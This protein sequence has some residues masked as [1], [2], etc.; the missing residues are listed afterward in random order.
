MLKNASSLCL[1]LALACSVSCASTKPVAT[2]V[3]PQPAAPVAVEPPPHAE[4]P[5]PPTVVGP[6]AAVA[7]DT[8]SATFPS[9]WQDPKFEDMWLGQ[10]V[11]NVPHQDW[12]GPVFRLSDRFPQTPQDDSGAQAWRSSKYDRMFAPGTPQTERSTL[13]NDYIWALMRYIQEGNIDSGDVA[14]D[15]S[16]CNNK[17]R[18]WYHIPFQTYDVRSGREFVHGL[19]REASVPFSL[20]AAEGAKSDVLPS[21][22]WA[23]AFYNPTAAYTLGTV[24][25]PDGTAQPPANDLAFEQGAVIGK[26]LF[27]TLAPEQM[28][29]LQNVPA[30]KANISKQDCKC[31]SKPCANLAEWSKACPRSLKGTHDSMVR[32]MQFDVAV[33]DARAAGTGWVFGTFVADGERRAAE[34]NPWNRIA[35][36]GLM[37]GNDGP[38][39]GELAA[40]TPHDPRTNG[41]TSEVIFWDTV[42]M[43]NAAGGATVAMRPGHLGCNSR[44]NGPADNASSSCMSCHMTA[45]VP[46]D[47]GMTPP[48]MAQFGG[49]TFECVTPDASDP[50]KGTDA[51]GGAAKVIH[52]VGFAQMDALFFANVPC[53]TPVSM[54]A[55]TAAGPVNVLGDG[56]PTYAAGHQGWIS[57]DYS[58]QL[59]IS[60]VQWGQWQQV[61]SASKQ[62]K[63]RSAIEPLL[64][65]R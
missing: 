52:D 58:L 3:E 30:W 24:W 48:I 15:W 29:F 49:I 62:A 39:V 1:L 35:P 42:D 59:S 46:D 57:L 34:P 47:K 53:G 36:L 7:S 41:F 31:S 18:N 20:K 17:V 61:A 12:S 19:T 38:K 55:Q 65:G 14:S 5:A 23:V 13:A 27:S 10:Q 28:P 45:S 37:W 56:V 64:P 44:L 33:K 11:T 26:L 4:P 63:R 6:K 60:L 51:G 8:C 54:T 50:T 22:V 9:Y 40:G 43:L 16:M 21:T 32:L 2:P 25:R